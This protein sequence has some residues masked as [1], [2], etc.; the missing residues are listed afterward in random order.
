[1]P[2]RLYLQTT[3]DRL[4]FVKYLI[5]LVEVYALS[6]LKILWDFGVVCLNAP[7]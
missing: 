1:M 4:H 5:H 2:I 7:K 3:N 6:A